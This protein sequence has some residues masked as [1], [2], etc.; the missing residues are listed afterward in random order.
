MKNF[1]KKIN[2]I[3]TFLSKGEDGITNKW[4]KMLFKEVY[5]RELS[6]KKNNPDWEWEVQMWE[7][8]EKS[9]FL[10][11]FVKGEKEEEREFNSLIIQFC[12]G[13]LLIGYKGLDGNKVRKLITESRFDAIKECFDRIDDQ[14]SF[15]DRH[16]GKE[17]GNFK[18]GDDNDGKFIDDSEFAWYAGNKTEEFADQLIAKVRKFQTPEI[19]ALFK[20]INAKCKI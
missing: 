13:T 14:P 1:L 17:G 4:W 16:I 5:N 7:Y 6:H 3:T 19:T 15:K 2:L 8:P 12:A 18:F 9:W 20:E 11:W 10:K